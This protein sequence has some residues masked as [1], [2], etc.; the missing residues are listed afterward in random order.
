[1]ELP[2][3]V[4]TRGLFWAGVMSLAVVLVASL[5]PTIPG[6]GWRAGVDSAWLP[7]LGAVSTLLS[8]LQSFGVLAIVA[9]LF[10]KALGDRQPATADVQP[11][12][13]DER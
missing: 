9:S 10:L 8:I 11:T 7:L 5:I 1:M 4:T 13:T 6:F 3:R 2:L 12:L